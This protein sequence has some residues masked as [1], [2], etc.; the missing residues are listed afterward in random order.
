MTDLA[1]MKQL[2][3]MNEA[4]YGDMDEVAFRKL[5]AEIQKMADRIE[6]LAKEGGPL[7]KRV[8]ALGGDVSY[9]GDLTQAASD[10]YRAS[11]EVE[12]GALAHRSQD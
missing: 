9:L 5:T 3:G 11:E 6:F 1:R 10:V 2:A 12:Y 7:Y 8:T 4:P